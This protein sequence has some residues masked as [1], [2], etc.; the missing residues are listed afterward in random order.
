MNRFIEYLWINNSNIYY[1]RAQLPKHPFFKRFYTEL[2]FKNQ[3]EI[4]ER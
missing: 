3:T 2:L 1:P 4:A